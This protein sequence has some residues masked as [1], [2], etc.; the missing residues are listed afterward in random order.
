MAAESTAAESTA[1]ESTAAES[2]A[3]ESTAAEG[4]MAGSASWDPGDTQGTPADPE[5]LEE[6]LGYFDFCR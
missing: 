2:T 6:L 4:S 3:A 5:A 1:A